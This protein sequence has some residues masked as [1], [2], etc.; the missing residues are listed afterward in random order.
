VIHEWAHVQR[1]DDVANCVQ[2]FVR[3]IAGWHPAIWWVDRRLRAERE[4]ACDEAA[5]QVTGSSKAYAACLA[6]L[7]ELK[8]EAQALPVPGALSASNLRRRVTHVLR[9]QGFASL[10]RD[11]AAVAATLGGVLACTLALSTHRIGVRPGSNGGQTVVEPGSDGGQTRLEPAFDDG[12]AGVGLQA[13][14]DPVSTRGVAARARQRVAPKPAVGIRSG[15]TGLTLPASRGLA[16]PA[17]SDGPA[18]A[19]AT[20]VD[21]GQTADAAAS[22]PSTAMPHMEETSPRQPAPATPWGAAS[23][24]GTAIGHGSQKA[25][26]TTAGF[27]TKLG[28]KIAASF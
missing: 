6:R 1:H 23:D 17:P 24:A 14:L 10:G 3:V 15:V 13:R 5:V 12:R 19:E 11:R 16:A 2:A 18:D 25:A 22:E 4:A 27:F 26:V 20:A 8:F 28:K 7:A 9:R 21:S